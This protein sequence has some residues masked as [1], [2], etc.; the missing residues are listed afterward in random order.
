MARTP[1]PIGG[2]PPKTTGAANH[3]QAGAHD[4]LDPL[5]RKLKRLGSLSAGDWAALDALPLV[6]SWA[7]ANSDLLR[8]GGIPS[9]C[10]LILEGFACR[11]KM[12]EDG[13]RQIISF[14]V[15][16]DIVEL[17]SVLQVPLDWSVLTLTTARVLP[18]KHETVLA[19]MHGHAGLGSLLWLDLL[20]DASIA[21]QWLVNI[22]R[23]TARECIAHLICELVV[24]L[25]VAG[26]AQ[27]QVCS[28]PFTQSEL[29]DAAGLTPVHVNRTMQELRRNGLIAL[30]HRTLTT[31]DWEAL[32]EVARF[33]PGYLRQLAA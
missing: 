30:S 9:E 2:T 15:P 11:Y 22:G 13:R 27:G 14:H 6:P 12:L 23:R 25:R 1:N 26:L 33:N 8:E 32:T 28:W 3:E 16:G 31:L 17:S 20:I 29:A 21:R 19:W 10:K 18:I 24:R 5:R 7:A 4:L